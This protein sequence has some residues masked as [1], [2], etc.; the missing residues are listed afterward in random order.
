MSSRALVAALV[1]CGVLVASTGSAMAGDWAF[2]MWGFWPREG[3]SPVVAMAPDG[4][5]VVVDE[6]FET[7][8]AWR[9]TPEEDFAGGTFGE[10]VSPEESVCCHRPEAPAVA[11]DPN[12]DIIVVWQEEIGSSGKTGVYTSFRP[13]G[14]SFSSPTLVSQGTS[15]DVAIDA[16]GE[17]IVSWLF[18]DGTSTVVEAA[19]ARMGGSF[20][21]PT[22][23]SGDGGDASDVRVSMDPGGDA[24]VSWTRSI[25]ASTELEAAVRRA[26]GHFP[27]PDGQGD[28]ARLGEVKPTESSELPLQHIVM[29]SAGEALAVWEAPGDAVQEARLA[30]GQSSFGAAATLGTTTAF[31]WVAMDEEGEAV[32]DWPIPGALDIATA[33]AGEGFGVPE[34]V[35]T[36]G[37]PELVKVSMAP[38]GTVTLAA[39]QNTAEGH[40]GPGCKEISEYGSVRPPGGTFA[41]ATGGTT[42]CGPTGSA[43]SLQIAGDSAGDTL[44]I[45]GESTTIGENVQGFV[46]DAGPSLSAVAIPTTAQ[47]GQPVSFGIASPVSVWRPLIGI[48]WEF[49]DG[50]TASG[51][52]VTHT[53]TQP[54]EYHITA[55]A[56]DAQLLAPGFPERHI[57]NSVTGTILI[58]PSPTA[59]S[60]ITPSPRTATPLAVPVI[61]HVHESHRAW[62]ERIPHKHRNGPPV[63][64]TV[65][66]ALN[67]QAN[68]RF[69]FTRLPGECASH[70]HRHHGHTCPRPVDV[71]SVSLAGRAGTDTLHFRG[72]L[73][74]TNWLAPGNYSLTI[75]AANDE[76]RST[77][78][79]LTF[80]IVG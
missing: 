16:N 72:Q 12:G 11:I 40:N 25:G 9:H 57:E 13:Q 55:S 39:L 36:E 71:G 8:R 1:V 64:T 20:S 54:G 58:T 45:W 33:P 30:S 77:A 26:G 47:V 53:Y 59:P 80:T 10:P 67:E 22:T 14:G 50:S 43:T 48:T 38:N 74:S 3:S 62:R 6:H 23:L 29:D 42:A 60:P 21:S 66:F 65:T 18:D 24:I 78:T 35:V 51:L 15:P 63:G 37:T 69:A 41:K 70:P 68:V 76:G 75:T 4:E 52:S 19:T 61:A 32:V 17:E 28:G 73:S 31:P 44:A 7:I 49:G 2:G 27:A 79:S 34:Q 5:A 56:A 46:Y